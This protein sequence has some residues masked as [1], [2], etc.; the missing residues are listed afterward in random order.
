MKYKITYT[1]QVTYTATV[2]AASKDEALDK[3]NTECI[4]NDNVIDSKAV[5]TSID[6]A[7]LAAH[8]RCYDV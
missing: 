1:E 7:A 6:D 4:I 3:F 5:H 8:I 2:E